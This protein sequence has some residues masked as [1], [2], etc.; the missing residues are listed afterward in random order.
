MT[1][2]GDDVAV[3]RA[4]L[5]I[6]RTALGRAQLIID[7]FSPESPVQSLGALARKAGLP[8]STAHRFVEQM[9]ELGWLERSH[10][11]YK[12]GIKLYEIGELCDR[13]N[14]LRRAATPH[15][16]ALSKQ[17][18]RSVWLCVLDGDTVLCLDRLSAP[19]A[20]PT[21]AGRR[22]RFPVLT[23]VFGR[24]I[25]A[26]ESDAQIDAYVDA[27]LADAEPGAVDAIRRDLAS[28]RTAGFAFGPSTRSETFFMGVPLR[29]SGRAIASITV[30]GPDAGLDRRTAETMHRVGA[31]IWHD[32]FPV[33]HE[34]RPA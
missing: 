28:V 14:S 11:G 19:T 5:P 30:A 2:L 23:T 33:R 26:F 15:L 12:V 1:V 10:R 16:L 17:L 29:Q 3:D 31:A 22:I 27:N 13:R 8:K 20:H 21:R 25:V 18:R 7:A 34:T 4:S 6:E 32:L 24:A 9:L